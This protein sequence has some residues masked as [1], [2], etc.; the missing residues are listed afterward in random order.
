MTGRPEPIQTGISPAPPRA[1]PPSS[2]PTTG[3]H[4]VAAGLHFRGQHLLPHSPAGEGPRTGGPQNAPYAEEGRL[5]PSSPT[6][7]PGLSA[8]PRPLRGT[9]RRPRPTRAQRRRG[10]PSPG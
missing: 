5:S 2:E 9:D 4:S 7:R 8:V 10:Q 1:V 6:D 3:R